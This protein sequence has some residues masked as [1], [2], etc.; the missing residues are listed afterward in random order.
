MSPIA[1]TLDDV[2]EAHAI[3]TGQAD[4]CPGQRER[5]IVR[6]PIVYADAFSRQFG[7]GARWRMPGVR[8]D[9][10]DLFQRAIRKERKLREEEESHRLLYVAMTRAE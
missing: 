5:V 1:V 7:L 10:D 3:L 9:K 6:T 4:Y 2:R 8:E